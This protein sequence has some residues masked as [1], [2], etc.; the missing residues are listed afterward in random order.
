MIRIKNSARASR[1]EITMHS[2]KLIH[3]IA[4]ALKEEG[5][6]SEVN[7]TD[8][9]ITVKLAYS[10]KKPV[11]MDL[12]L[13]SNPGLRVY[14]NLDKLK[15]RKVRSSILILSTPKGVMSH[16]KAIKSMNGGEVIAEI[17]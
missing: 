1:T 16:K 9:I 13:V 14:N 8:G 3:A 10:H 4:N 12:K 11:L 5:F 15:A 2:T 6:L 17:W 7:V